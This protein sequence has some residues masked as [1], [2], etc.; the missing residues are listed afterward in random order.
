MQKIM[1]I[2][3]GYGSATRL[4]APEPCQFWDRLSNQQQRNK[5]VQANGAS[6]RKIP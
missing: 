3:G 6:H 2:I 1:F 4:G 5:K